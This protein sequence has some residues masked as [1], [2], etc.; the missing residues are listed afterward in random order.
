MTLPS[1]RQV[2]GL[3]I[4]AASAVWLRPAIAIGAETKS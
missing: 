2:I 4:G 3:G 1:R